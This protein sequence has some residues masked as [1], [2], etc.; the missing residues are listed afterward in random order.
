MKWFR[1]YGEMPDDPKI[2]TLND[3]EFRTWVEL[4]CLACKEEDNGVTPAT[5]QNINWLLRRDVTV[6][7][8]ELLQRALL[9]ENTDGFIII[10]K[11]EDRQKLSDSSAKR[12]RKFREK[13]KCNVTSAECNALEKRREDKENKKEEIVGLATDP[14]I[15][16]DFQKIIAVWNENLGSIC[17]KIQRLTDQR[18]RLIASRMTDSFENNL[19]QWA[20][21][22]KAIKASKFCTGDNDRGWRANIDWALKPA[23]INKVLEGNYGT[24]KAVIQPVS[25]ETRA[26]AIAWKRDKGMP[27]GTADL[28]ELEAFESV[29]GKINLQQQASA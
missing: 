21:Y 17:P 4:L 26:K 15:K 25:P 7:L 12:V 16:N 2:G 23:T 22:C 28:S 1:M 29:H 24:Q 5:K 10:T 14:P 27:L 8:H 3:A 6:T 19:E 11:W 18:K 13:E 20:S 9:S